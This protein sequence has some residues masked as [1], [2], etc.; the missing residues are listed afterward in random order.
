MVFDIVDAQFAVYET[1][2]LD[3]GLPTFQDLPTIFTSR[4]G[5]TLKKSSLVVLD[6]EEAGDE[7]AARGKA[8]KMLEHLYNLASREPPCLETFSSVY[9]WSGEG[10]QP[11]GHPLIAGG[12]GEWMV[13]FLVV[14]VIRDVRP[15]GH[16][17]KEIEG[18]VGE[19]HGKGEGVEAGFGVWNREVFIS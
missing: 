13:L 15:R 2:L 18:W 19:E 16:L 10:A 6:F 4:N 1:V 5:V 8:V 11:E 7:M 9:K 3:I 12:R 17:V 14:D